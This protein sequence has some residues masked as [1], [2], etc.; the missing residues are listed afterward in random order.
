MTITTFAF[1]Q[2]ELTKLLSGASDLELDDLE[3][4]IIGF[5][6]SCTVVRYNR[7]ESD[8]AGLSPE[9]VLG[10]QRH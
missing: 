9:R 7:F 6:S 10:G 2:P 5:D 1:D 4:G 3:F 8:I